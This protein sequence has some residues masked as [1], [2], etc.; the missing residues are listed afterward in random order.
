MPR[1]ADMLGYRTGSQ[2]G[3]GQTVDRSIPMATP[4]GEFIPTPPTA[5]QEAWQ[6]ALSN[7]SVAN[8]LYGAGEATASLL[9]SPLPYV[10]GM[11]GYGYGAL[12][13]KDPK[14][15]GAQFEQT[16][17]LQPKTALGQYYA[18]QAGDKLSALP[19][20]ISGIP[21]PRLGA[22]AT[23]YAG[24]QYGM[25]M[26]EKSMTMYEQGKLT[27]GFTPISEIFIG[28]KAKG[29]NP[30]L[31]AK[32]VE[33]EKAGAT[34]REIWSQTM[35]WKGP[36]GKW[37]QE[38]DDSR[39]VLDMAKLPANET[40]KVHEA[41]THDPL[42]ANYPGTQYY[43]LGYEKQPNVRGSFNKSQSRFTTGG[44]GTLFDP[45][46]AKST[47]L[48]EIQHG[49]QSK[50][51][52]AMGGNPDQ[53][54]TILNEMRKQELE[55]LAKGESNW[56]FA[57]NQLGRASNNLYMHKLNNLSQSE[58]IRPR[59]LTGLADFYEYSNQIRS[60][61]GPM[62]KRA[63]PER[64]S[65]I[66]NAANYIK[67]KNI[68]KKPY[69]ANYENTDPKKQQSIYRSASRVMDKFGP[70]AFK[71]RETVAKYKTIAELTPVEKYMRSAGEAEA[72]ATQA[73]MNLSMEER[74]ALFP[75]E[76]Y[77]RPVKD[78]IT[79]NRETLLKKIGQA[80]MNEPTDIFSILYK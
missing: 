59:Q 52:F 5:S 72:R 71:W 2:F 58:N 61:Y 69:L 40:I 34:P 65:W 74:R 7:P 11:V 15:T 64:D 29:W 35:N 23:R 77:D 25:P 33:M 43:E 73:R 6:G 4:T 47:L 31:N 62:P 36:E 76:S 55:P 32:A 22:G 16:T 75:E 44:A 48:H 56:K 20:V 54:Q 1:A 53:M 68:E 10:A 3:A 9:S 63:G 24:Q 8:I 13:G 42:Y 26:L 60:E 49:I 57:A 39:A 30:E 27:P 46:A 41:L 14:E 45:E 18:E 78:L 21:T 51:D 80:E 66:R 70:D 19:P 28:E 67:E 12:T 38:I 37:R 79:Y 50:E 17:T